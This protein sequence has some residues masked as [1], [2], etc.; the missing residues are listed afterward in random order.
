[1]NHFNAVVEY[2]LPATT[3]S[4]LRI[5]RFTPDIRTQNEMHAVGF[6]YRITAGQKTAESLIELEEDLLLES[7]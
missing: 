2:D 1:M 7:A 4:W 6:Q 5:M 3:K